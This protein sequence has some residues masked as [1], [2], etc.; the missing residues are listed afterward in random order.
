MK[1]RPVKPIPCPAVLSQ[2]ANGQAVLL[3]LKGEHYFGLD[4]VGTRIWQLLK[5]GSDMPGLLQSL[6]DEF[7]APRAQIEA[8]VADLLER[9]A[10]AGLVRFS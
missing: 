8:D 1:D 6:V 2:E 4:D 10:K 9:M 3:D 7:D 5:S